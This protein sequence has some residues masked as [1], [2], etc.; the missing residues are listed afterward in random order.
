MG[1][2]QRISVRAEQRAKASDRAPHLGAGIGRRNFLQALGVSLLA[3]CAPAALKPADTG[4]ARPATAQSTA[5]TPVATWRPSKP[6]AL[7]LPFNPG[8]GF[9]ALARQLA[10]AMEGEL[11]QPVVVKNVEGGA[12]RIAAREFQRAAPDGYTIGYFADPELFASTTVTPADGFD[13]Q[14]WVWVAGLET[15]DQTV[16]VAQNSPYKTVDA[17]LAAGARGQRLRFGHSG[18]AGYLPYQVIFAKVGGFTNAVMVGGFQGTADLIPALIRGDLD[19]Q[20]GND[21]ISFLKFVRSGDLRA[22][23]T[24]AE[25]RLP[26][27]PDVP[28]AKEANLP[29]L[30]TLQTLNVSY[31]IVA[32]PNTPQ[33]AVRSLEQAALNALKAPGFQEWAATTGK[34]DQL[35]PRTAQQ[36]APLKK[37][38]Y[39]TFLKFTDEFKKYA[40][41]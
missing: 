11:G 20:S 19:V 18:I 4:S 10:K 26:S 8:G 14:S 33:D 29:D 15:R 5:T 12:Q 38:E 17:L 30:P 16:Y 36:I 1:D 35:A 40:S 31:G 27:L 3:A 22:L 21:I 39:T 34:K 6:V 41:G 7:I 24:L 25:K 2:V 28:T 23:V 32:P 37:G 9:D 13:I